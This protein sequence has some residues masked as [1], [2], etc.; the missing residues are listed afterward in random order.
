MKWLPTAENWEL[1]RGATPGRGCSRP[2]QKGE[3][4]PTIRCVEIRPLANLFCCRAKEFIVDTRSRNIGSLKTADY[5]FHKTDW[6][7]NEV[8]R[9]ARITNTGQ[10]AYVN[11]T[12]ADTR[13]QIRICGLLIKT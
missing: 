5:G 12:R 11:L 10:P 3:P 13:V 1:R 4:N 9:G 8:V 6:T 7:A 2:P